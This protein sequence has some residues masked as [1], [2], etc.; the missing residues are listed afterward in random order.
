MSLRPTTLTFAGGSPFFP[1]DLP[2]EV[3]EVNADC[4]CTFEIEA[5][6]KLIRKDR[7]TSTRWSSPDLTGSF[8]ILNLPKHSAA[9]NVYSVYIVNGRVTNISLPLG[10]VQKPLC[11]LDWRWVLDCLDCDR[12]ALIQA[13]TYVGCIELIKL[14]ERDS[15]Y[16]TGDHKLD[17]M[18]GMAL[19]RPA[20]LFPLK[21]REALDLLEDYQLRALSHWHRVP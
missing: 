13:R 11:T 4:N 5:S 7:L 9:E 16:K 20:M 17:A 10:G 15:G 21:P 8:T 3:W 19:C 18:I 12:E 2:L 6:G 1:A 14:A